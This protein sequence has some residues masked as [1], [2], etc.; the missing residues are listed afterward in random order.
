MTPY[1]TWD[2]YRDCH[3]GSLGEDD[4]R[5]LAVD[6][7]REIDRRTFGRAGQ[8]PKEMAVP[9]K[10]CECALIDAAYAYEACDGL[11]PKGI[12][13]VGNDG[14]T[15]TRSSADIAREKANAFQEICEKWLR[16]PVNLLYRGVTEHAHC[17]I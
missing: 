9:L 17:H 5:R 11:L 8:A 7:C 1:S 10:L 15:M 14:Y 4:Y 16:R 6:A 3:R 12:G 13:S 2:F